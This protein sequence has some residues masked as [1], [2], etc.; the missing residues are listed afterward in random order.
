MLL[1]YIGC[2][3]TILGMAIVVDSCSTRSTGAL[4]LGVLVVSGGLMLVC[5]SSLELDNQSQRHDVELV[6][7]CSV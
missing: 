2:V 6:D 3:A 4:F 1:F 7:G 5:T